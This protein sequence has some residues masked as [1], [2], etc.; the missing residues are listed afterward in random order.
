MNS[1]YDDSND[2]PRYVPYQLLLLAVMQC[3]SVDK[4]CCK[5]PSS[6]EVTARAAAA[7]AYQTLSPRVN[8][9]NVISADNHCLYN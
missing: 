6:S 8:S 9:T 2:D 1:N 7:V 5:R 3:V 4:C